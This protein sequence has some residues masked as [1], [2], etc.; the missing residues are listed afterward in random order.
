MNDDSRRYVFLS[1]TFLSKQYKSIP[2]DVLES[3]IFFFG[4]KRSWL[5]PASRE[6]MLEARS[7]PTRYLEFDEEFKS[8]VLHKEAQRQ[9]F[10]L[11][12]G[13]DF[14]K[15]SAF[16]EAITDPASKKGYRPLILDESWWLGDFNSKDAKFCKDARLI[17]NNFKQG[18][19]DYDAV[20]E[21]LY[22]SNPTLVPTLYWAES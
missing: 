8:L 17:V 10:W 7:L 5:F 16:L 19:F 14:S 1:A 3:C 2:A 9:V 4:S 11:L 21:L 15:G 12:P 6:E 20:M 22:Q 13:K 18:E